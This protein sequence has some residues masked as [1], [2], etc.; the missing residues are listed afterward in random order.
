MVTSSVFGPVVGGYLTWHFGWRSIFLINV[1][2]SLLAMALSFRLAPGK[3]RAKDWTFDAW[4]LVLYVAAITPALLTLEQVQNSAG[5]SARVLALGAVAVVAATLLVRQEQR[6]PYPLLPVALL[7]QPTIWRSD[8]LA[9]CHGAVLVSLVTFLPLFLHVDRQSSAADTGV[10]L[11]PLMCGIGVGSMLTG[12]IVSVTGYTTIMP[13]CGLL[14][15]TAGLT[16]L[17]F[18]AAHMS[19]KALAW[20]LLLSGLSMGTVMG[21]VQVTVQNAA[22]G[23]NL[24]A[25]AASVQLARSVGAAVGTALVG[26]I[27]FS[28]IGHSSPQTV[29][30]FSAMVAQNSLLQSPQGA[31]DGEIEA[32]FRAAFLTVA[33]FA[34]LGAAL[35][36]SIPSRRLT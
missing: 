24:G 26:S 9:G 16:L 31:V 7:R 23:A 1:P 5:A 32:A 15:A 19:D 18:E 33:A 11:L 30:Y 10:L 21:V 20:L 14:A 4:G 35:A 22:G 13:S 17:A 8:A 3:A 25:A 34:A 29:A 6:A 27:L 36:W 2:L 12:R 28:W